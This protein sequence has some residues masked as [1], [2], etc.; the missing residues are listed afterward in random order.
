[1]KSCSTYVFRLLHSRLS[2]DPLGEDQEAVSSLI[3]PIGSNS[4]SRKWEEAFLGP[5]LWREDDTNT[6]TIEHYIHHLYL[7]IRHLMCSERFLHHAA[8]HTRYARCVW[9]LAFHTKL[10]KNKQPLDL[11][12]YS[13]KSLTTCFMSIR[14]CI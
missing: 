11:A 2:S 1:M 7:T 8:E 3:L 5:R 10:A 14:C 13:G 6:A 9:T 4:V 12:V